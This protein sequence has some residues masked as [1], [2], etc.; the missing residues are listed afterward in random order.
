VAGMTNSEGL[1][2]HPL[3]APQADLDDLADRLVRTRWPIGPTDN[4]WSRGVPQDDLRELADRWRSAFDWRAVEAEL[5]RW[6]P[7]MATVDNQDI[8]VLHADSPEPGALPL[9]L[10]HGYPS[11]V[12]EFLEVMGPL[13]D[14]AAHGANPEDA[15][16][17]IA[18][19]LPGFGLSPPVQEHGWTSARMAN[20]FAAIVRRLGY[21]RYGVAGGDVGA[22]VAQDMA[23]ADPTSVVG[24][25][26][27]T[28]MLST[29][30][31]LSFAGVIVDPAGFDDTQRRLIER[32]NHFVQEGLGYIALQQ[33]RPATVGYGLEDSPIA[34][35]AWIMEKFE[36][37]T[38][39]SNEGRSRTIDR[40]RLLATVTAYWLCHNGAASAHF[41]YDAGHGE[42][43]WGAQ[44]SAPRG[45]AVFGGGGS[46][47]RQLMDPQHEI[48][49]WS[50]YSEGGHF[51][52]LEAPQQFVED[53]RAFFRPL[54]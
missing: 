35:L 9:V 11:S 39:L 18:P 20:A 46:V 1:R 40:D 6:N 37:W 53:V 2:P 15:F 44:P 54:R 48:P 24:V 12:V 47:V 17:V 32:M 13:S 21:Q 23:L 3:E 25:H 10:N 26:V 29:A 16:H 36:E 8:L 42:R 45:W 49:H 41:L 28:D 19:S 4:D 38:D 52:P 34:Q 5:N 43:D 33:S 14:P 51:A 22:G 27:I 31:V 7:T 30:A 50:E